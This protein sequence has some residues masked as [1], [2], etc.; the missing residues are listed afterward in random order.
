LLYFL[1]GK[2]EVYWA[3]VVPHPRSA[4]LIGAVYLGAIFFYLL[5]LRENEWRQ[6]QNGMGGLVVFC[7]VLVVATMI[8][9]EQ[10][11]AYHITTIVWFIFY[12]LGPF[13][14]PIV[15][16]KQVS[17]LEGESDEGPTIPRAW[18]AWLIARGFLYL[19]FALFG[20]IFTTPLETA[21]PWP[22]E[23]LE[24]RVFM[25]QPAI[26][27]WNSAIALR[28]GHAWKRYRLGLV[29]SG[30]VGFLQLVGLFLS[31]TPYDWPSPMGVVLPVIFAEWLVTPLVIH[32]IYR[33]K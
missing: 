17:Q 19:A 21:W 13:I 11:R 1:P 3:W 25:G 2:S 16:R 12:Y 27:G 24:L 5:A 18:R 32:I 8:H 22:I 33:K 20:L 14:V 7:L 6:V 15:Y 29:L 28:G 4:I 23:S 26:I 10:F 30:A 31:T 9:W